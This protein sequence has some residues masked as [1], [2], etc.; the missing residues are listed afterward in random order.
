MAQSHAPFQPPREHFLAIAAKIELRAGTQESEQLVQMVRGLID[1]GDDP[2]PVDV[3]VLHVLDER[4]RH[5]L[6]GQDIVGQARGDGALGHAGVIGR[7][8]VLNHGHAARGLDRLEPQR[9]VR[10]GPAQDDAD[11]F[12]QLIVG[13][14]AQKEID[15]CLPAAALHRPGQ[16]EHAAGDGHV[17]V[18]RDDVDA[19]GLDGHALSGLDD[20]H[21]RVPGEQL[22]HQAFVRGV[23][24]GDED[25]G[26]TAVRGHGGEKLLEG[27]EPAGRSDQ[28][29]HGQFQSAS[30]PRR[31]ILVGRRRRQFV[32]WFRNADRTFRLW[33][34]LGPF[35]SRRTLPS[36][37][38]SRPSP[39]LLHPSTSL[40]SH[41]SQ[42]CTNV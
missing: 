13:Q 11:R 42:R 1:R 21:G 22:D 32:A 29:G 2:A 30:F 20:R 3:A 34:R 24:V 28:P 25:E 33:E 35:G 7:L 17:L 41:C 37:V 18:G 39:V 40:A 8:G 6:D 9:P 14:R 15:R 5:L 36:L 27:V 23:E 4:F 12:F 26:D 19:V 16:A 10:P 31:G 38:F